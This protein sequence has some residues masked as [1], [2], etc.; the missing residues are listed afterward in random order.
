MQRYLYANG[1]PLRMDNPSHYQKPSYYFRYN[2]RGD[3]A[4]SVQQNGDGGAGWTQFGAWGDINYTSIGYYGWNAAWGYMQFPANLNFNLHD[5]QDMGL[6]FA[7]GRWYNQETGLWLSPDEKG[8]YGYEPNNDPVNSAQSNGCQNHLPPTTP[9]VGGQTVDWIRLDNPDTWF[10]DE[11]RKTI[12]RLKSDIRASAMRHNTSKTNMDDNAFAALLT[13]ILHWEGK[14]PGNGNSASHQRE[15]WLKDFADIQ[16]GADFSAGIAKI[17]PS[18]ALEILK[19][20]I[21]NRPGQYCYSVTGG[22]TYTDLMSTIQMQGMFYTPFQ[23]LAVNL[24]D[25][26]ASI[27]YLAANLERGADRIN[28]FGFQAS[29]FNLGAWHNTGLQ[30]PNEILTSQNGPKARSYGNTVLAAMP[31]AFNVLSIQGLYLPYNADGQQFIDV[32]NLKP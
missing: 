3:A 4:A 31:R 26:K 8:D 18:V 2:A 5:A 29:A 12:A 10:P 11:E 17:K 28:G 9:P 16:F 32:G 20:E 21:P 14:L 27:D 6:Y 15:D 13:A 1:R 19:G 23:I 30:T 22:W 7:H 25:Q 24:Q